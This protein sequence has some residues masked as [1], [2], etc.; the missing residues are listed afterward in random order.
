MTLLIKLP[1]L[2]LTFAHPCA[3]WGTT[4]NIFKPLSLRPR[5]SPLLVPCPKS[6][7]PIQRY[8]GIFLN[9]FNG[10]DNDI[11]TEEDEND[12]IDVNI[13]LDDENGRTEEVEGDD[14]NVEDVINEMTNIFNANSKNRRKEKMNNILNS[15]VLKKNTDFISRLTK[16][17]NE[18]EALKNNQDSNRIN[19]DDSIM[20]DT[21]TYLEYSR[22]NTL[23]V[24]KD[25][26]EIQKRNSN[27]KVPKFTSTHYNTNGA[28][29]CAS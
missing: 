21:E 26:E 11:S 29:H 28:V 19:N 9:S 20:L 10:M 15:T 22:T 25:Q 18:V 4:T 24:V 13:I 7:S 8:N 23:R 17:S 5:S 12:T 27:K 6:I 2:T 16:L 1:L 3:S 14:T